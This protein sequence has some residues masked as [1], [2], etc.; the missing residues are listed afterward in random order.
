MIAPIPFHLR[1]KIIDTYKAGHQKPPTRKQAKAWLAP[2]RRAM[3][4]LKSG[5]VDAHRGYV[6]TRLNPSDTDF[7]R[8]DHCINGFTAMM[9]RLMPEFDCR[10]LKTVSRK[11]S[12]GILLTHQEIEACFATLN[13]CEDRL[14]K[15]T[16]AALKDAAVTEQINIEL[17]LAGLK[18]AA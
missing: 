8:I 6:I 5:E 18:E 14:I 16:R 4:E 10:S 17:E 15:F 3:A 2:I 9:D 13:D 1:R 12:N 7:A 11:L